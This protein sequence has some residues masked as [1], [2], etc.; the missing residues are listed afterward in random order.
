MGG[1]QR[2]SGMG[3]KGQSQNN[4][5]NTGKRSFEKIDFAVDVIL[6]EDN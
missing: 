3:K 6:A 2:G 5:N 4:G 1:S